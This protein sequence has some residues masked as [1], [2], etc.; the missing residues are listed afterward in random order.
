MMRGRGSESKNVSGL[1]LEKV[2]LSVVEGWR[3]G[4]GRGWTGGSEEL[5]MRLGMV[6]KDCCRGNGKRTRVND[7]RRTGR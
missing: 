4:E 5:R 3:P 2:P 6:M 1:V 7:I